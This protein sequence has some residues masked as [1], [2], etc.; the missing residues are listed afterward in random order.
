MAFVFALMF[1]ISAYSSH[2]YYY[3]DKWDGSA[4]LG[5]SG[6]GI[7]IQGLVAYRVIDDVLREADDSM[8]FE[9]GV[10]IISA[11]DSFKKNHSA[12]VFEIPLKM[13]WDIHVRNSKF[14]VSPDAGFV[15]ISEDGLNIQIG[16]SGIYSYSSNMKLR[17]GIDVGGFS[18]LF[19]GLN[20]LL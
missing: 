14:T 20:F 15:Y 9:T 11:S 8:S 3:S 18:T 17:F 10:G 16:V 5:F 7:G 12:T 4:L 1:S 2:H 6:P 19:V 13:R